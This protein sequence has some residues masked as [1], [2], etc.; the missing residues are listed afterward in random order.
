MK[1]LNTLFRFTLFGFFLESFH[2]SFFHIKEYEKS[3]TFICL[4]DWGKGGNGGVYG[5]AQQGIYL[6][7][8]TDSLQELV[9]EEKSQHQQAEKEKGSGGSDKNNEPGKGGG[10]TSKKQS[11]QL[12]IAAAM[13]NVAKITSPQPSFIL[14]LGDNFYTNGVPSSTS[15]LW[16]YLWKDV[17]LSNYPDLY[18]PWYPVFGNHDYQGGAA[19]VQAQLDR[20]REHI[21]DDIWT[22]PSSNYTKVFDIPGEA[23]GKVVIIFIDTTTLAPSE[24]KS[25]NENG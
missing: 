6:H 20:S 18:I 12:A 7:D 11:Y 21:D 8:K 23:G 3:L 10:G 15:S 17:Y 22:F 1:V 2:A 16:N 25:T 19:A 5:S 13:S 9:V 4:G 24:T 14:T